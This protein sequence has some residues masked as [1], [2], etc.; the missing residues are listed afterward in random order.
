[1]AEGFGVQKA[2]GQSKE[3]PV[4]PALLL[5]RHEHIVIWKIFRQEN[6][7]SAVSLNPFRVNF[8]NKA[9][10]RFIYYVPS[11]VNI[12]WSNKALYIH[13][14]RNFRVATLLRWI[15]QCY[16]F[17]SSLR[18]IDFLFSFCWWDSNGERTIICCENVTSLLAIKRNVRTENLLSR[19]HSF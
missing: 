6:R 7:F 19:G 17:N 5:H 2:E 15:C 16:N 14:S 12:L 8:R 3:R 9:S 18:I 10:Q 11:L 1:M 13:V 4:C